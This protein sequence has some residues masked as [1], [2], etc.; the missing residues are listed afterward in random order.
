MNPLKHGTG[1]AYSVVKWRVRLE[2]PEYIRNSLFK[3]LRILVRSLVGT[4]LGGI[5]PFGSIYRLIARVVVPEQQKLVKVN[6]YRLRVRVEK[7]KDIDG[8]AQRLIFDGKYEYT[9][10]RVVQEIV[11]PGMTA[12]DIGANIG[13]YTV[14]LSKL[15]G[16]TGTVWAFEPELLNLTE[17]IGNVQL[18]G[19][20][21]VIV[22]KRAIGR[23]ECIHPLHICQDESGAH[24][25]IDI[26]DRKGR[27]EQVEVTTLD[28]IFSNTQVHFIKCDTEG[29]EVNVLLGA[30]NLL[31]RQ[32][33]LPILMLEVWPEGLTLSGHNTS[34]LIDI[35]ESYKYYCLYL[36]DEWKNQIWRTD[37]DL[38]LHYYKKYKFAANIICSKIPIGGLLNG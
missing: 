11:R 35:L 27:I 21:N 8:I 26:P 14:M 29:N 38:I 23:E 7:G 34:D 4:G 15:V 25:L 17:L 22:D 19:C 16:N 6:G 33:S 3:L 24:S 20:D 18:N 28:S 9:A 31:Q 36:I 1:V 37:L 32:E 2:L 5:W 13:Y 30:K 12:I 10:S